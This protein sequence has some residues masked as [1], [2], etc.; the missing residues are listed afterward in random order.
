MVNE[1]M[2]KPVTVVHESDSLHLVTDVLLTRH[3]GC[4]PVVDARE[5]ICGIITAADL[6]A[7]E[8]SPPARR[9]RETFP[10]APGFVASDEAAR[11]V[12]AREVMTREVITVTEDDSL[13]TVLE[14]MLRE[15][16]NRLP[17]VRDGAPVGMIARHDLLRLLARRQQTGV[18]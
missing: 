11:I 16:L 2:V 15:D 6:A 4:V 5:R 17:V 13:D 3:I 10:P 9:A 18:V 12:T 1:L 7:R 8:T 14:L